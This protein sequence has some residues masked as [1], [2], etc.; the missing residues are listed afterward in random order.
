LARFPEWSIIRP[1]GQAPHRRSRLSS[2]VSHQVHRPAYDEAQGLW[3]IEGSLRDIYIH[4]VDLVD[5]NKLLELSSRFT[6]S[7]T[8]DGVT[9]ALPE[10]ESIFSNRDGSHL[11]RLNLGTV[12]ANCHFFVVSEIELDLDPREVQSLKAHSEVLS[13]IESLAYAVGKPVLLTPEN[14]EHIPYISFEPT[15]GKWNVHS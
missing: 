12:T 10:V 8:F 14:G 15:A 3:E 9:S 5:W 1:A 13:F 6:C 2:N 7:Y 11:L 4:K